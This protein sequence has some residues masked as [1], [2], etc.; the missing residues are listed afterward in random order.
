[1]NENLLSVQNI[2]A[3][4][5][6]QKL[7]HVSLAKLSRDLNNGIDLVGLMAG[8]LHLISIVLFIL[9]LRLMSLVPWQL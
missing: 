1:M 5:T 7:L 9:F 2:G 6:C 4:L 8:I 3:S